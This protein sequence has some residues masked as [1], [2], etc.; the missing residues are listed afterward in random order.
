M[1][2]LHPAILVL[3]FALGALT[4]YTV[5]LWVTATIDTFNDRFR[6]LEESLRANR[7]ILRRI[8]RKTRF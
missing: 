6:Q 7:E 2:P 8:E 1:T 4:I 5:F 3:A